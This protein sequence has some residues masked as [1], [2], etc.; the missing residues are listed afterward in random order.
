MYPNGV[1]TAGAP[2]GPSHSDHGHVRD[3]ER[4][5]LAGL[6]ETEAAAELGRLFRAHRTGLHRYL[7]RRIGPTTAD[8][9]VG[10]TFLAA[11]RARRRYDPTR[12]DA[13]AWL[14][15]IASNVL[16]A[17]QRTEV[18][19][20]R[21]TARLA[22]RTEEPDAD[23]AESV[24]G[25]VDAEHRVRQLAAA[26]AELSAEDRDLLLLA[27]WADLN[28]TEIGVALDIPAGTVRSRLHRIRRQ[29][30]ARAPLVAV[31]DRRKP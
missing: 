14:Y 12:A 3:S 2:R 31:S 24:A 20:L 11:M 1:S 10:E 9:V 25:R 28:A 16:R 21:V 27:S 4:P 7:A 6:P 26:L 30:R 17:H 8:D 19:A 15:G 18:R 23:P 13:R 5:D 29:L 22:H